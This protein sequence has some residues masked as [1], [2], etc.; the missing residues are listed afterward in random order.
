MSHDQSPVSIFMSYAHADR[1]VTR[2]LYLRLRAAGFGVFLDEMKLSPEQHLRVELEKN[3]D[4]SSLFLLLWSRNANREWVLWELRQAVERASASRLRILVLALDDSDRPEEVREQIYIDLTRSL[5]VGS[6][7]L[8]THLQDPRLR[9]IPVAYGTAP[10]QVDV[11]ELAWHLETSETEERHWRLVFDDLG[12]FL[13]L[14]QLFSLP[15]QVGDVPPDRPLESTRLELLAETEELLSFGEKVAT[16]ILR[17]QPR[18]L[19]LESARNYLS[20]L[21]HRC[22][23]DMAHYITQHE[24]ARLPELWKARFESV[25]ALPRRLGSFGIV[26][27]SDNDCAELLF[28]ADSRFDEAARFIWCDL[29]PRPALARA[30]GSGNV[31][32]Q[33]PASR[34]GNPLWVHDLMRSGA[35]PPESHLF[36]ERAWALLFVPWIAREIT[37]SFSR[38]EFDE[39]AFDAVFEQA[40]YEQLG[41]H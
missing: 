41:L 1:T 35:W 3:L 7:A 10:Y 24:F 20:W 29:L 21:V 13:L 40:N 33:L 6:V 15:P 8:L 2:Y 22:F 9:V 34:N 5:R 36:D 18:A 25:F 17:T 12:V 37:F 27:Y 28:G 30:I 26:R 38:K 16:A 39:K 19:A 32:M 23:I 4:R 11:T 14:E 31:A